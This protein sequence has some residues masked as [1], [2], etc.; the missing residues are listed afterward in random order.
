[1]QNILQKQI[2]SQMVPKGLK[3]RMFKLAESHILGQ[4][5]KTFTFTTGVAGKPKSNDLPIIPIPKSPYYSIQIGEDSCFIRGDSLGIA[6]GVGGWAGVSGANPAIYS[7]KLMHYV[8]SEL[9]KLDYDYDLDYDFYKNVN[10][11]EILAKG[12]QQ[13]NEDCKRDSILGSTTAL[14]AILRDAE[15]RISSI[16]DCGIMVVRDKEP[17]FRNEEQQHSFNCP[18][19]LGVKSKDTPNDAQH[20][21]IPIQEGDIVVVGSDGLFD[22]V[23][24]EQILEIINSESDAQKIADA[25]LNKAR[26]VAEETESGASPFQERAVREGYYYQGGKADDMT[27]VIGIVS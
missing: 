26:E 17:V 2:I 15:L 4:F 1:M 14:I 23:F 16:G 21:T 10:A 22:N 12:Y 19:Q 24:D 3:K 5:H 6:D 11:T 27:V 25:L 9:Q 7:L 13:V 18:Y 20:Y 8:Y